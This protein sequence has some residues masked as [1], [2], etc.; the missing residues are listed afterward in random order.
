MS[1]D[2]QIKR[3]QQKLQQV[4]KKQDTVQKENAMLKEAVSKFKNDNQ[5]LRQ[6]LEVLELQVNILKTSAGQLEGEEKKEFER[7]INFFVKE[8]DRCIALLSQ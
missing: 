7:K 1:Y 4:A 8:L 6:Q 2:E 5:G 3:I